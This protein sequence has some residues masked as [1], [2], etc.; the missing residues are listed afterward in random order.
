MMGDI[1]ND[2]DGK[3]V[4][5]KSGTDKYIGRYGG[6]LTTEA[7]VDSGAIGLQPAFYYISE[8]VQDQQ[9]NIARQLMVTPVELCIGFDSTVIVKNFDVVMWFDEM[10]AEDKHQFEKAVRQGVDI[11]TEAK[12]AKAGITLETTMPERPSANSGLLLK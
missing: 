11:M 5:V 3:W 8:L 9:G 6:D 12:A 2:Y 7:V 10:S 4:F 1:F